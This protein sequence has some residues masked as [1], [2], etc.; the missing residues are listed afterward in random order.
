MRCAKCGAYFDRDAGEGPVA[1]ISGSIMGDEHTDSFYFC[2][3]CQVYT[4]EMFHDRFLGEEGSSV[5][6]PVP[7]EEG[8][9]QVAL[10]MQCPEPWNKRCRCPAHMAYFRG[11][12]D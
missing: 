3:S 2:R 9:A 8:D 6:G 5:Q 7:K 4:V 1:S 11:Q 10:V 12:L